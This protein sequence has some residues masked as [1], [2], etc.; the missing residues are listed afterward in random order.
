MRWKNIKSIDTNTEK[1][2][3]F[4]IREIIVD[5]SIFLFEVGLKDR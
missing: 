5:Y 3:S 2:L 4:S 1:K